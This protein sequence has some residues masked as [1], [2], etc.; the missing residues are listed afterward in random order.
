M[1]EYSARS[2]IGRFFGVPEV[3]ITE[4]FVFMF[5][6]IVLFVTFFFAALT[7]GAITT[8]NEKDGAKYIPII[9]I[10]GFILYFGVRIVLGGVLG[11]V[12]SFVTG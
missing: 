1:A 5:G 9:A 11:N 3:G 6:A 2:P 10:I 7:I 8:G 12:T 4:E